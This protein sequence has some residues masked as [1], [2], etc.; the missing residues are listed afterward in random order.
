MRKKRAFSKVSSFGELP[1]I[2]LINF[3]ETC[4]FLA[5]LSFILSILKETGTGVLLLPCCGL[6]NRGFRKVLTEAFAVL[7]NMGGREIGWLK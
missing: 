2:L 1:L 6:N 4:L 5:S 3:A 7:E